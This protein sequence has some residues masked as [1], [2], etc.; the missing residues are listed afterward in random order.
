[1]R[2][3]FSN[4]EV[5]ELK[6]NPCVHSC[7][8]K[9]VNYTYEFKKRAIELYSQGI[10]P[11]EIWRRSDFDVTKWKKNYFHLTIR[12]WRKIVSKHGIEGLRRV[13]GIQYD[14]GPDNTNKDKIK[15]LEL[16]VKYLESEN[17]FLAQL[18]AKRAESNSGRVK[19]FKSLEN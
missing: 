19:N 10:S 3:I 11:K 13:G 9:S 7:T 4:E 17:L 5:I 15:R 16:Q 14:R 12:D 1:M 6:N 18:R 8:S 2:T